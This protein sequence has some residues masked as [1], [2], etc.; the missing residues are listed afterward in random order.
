MKRLLST[1]TVLLLVAAAVAIGTWQQYRQFTVT[2]LEVAQPGVVLNVQPGDTLGAVV[3]RLGSQG[4]TE[5]GWRWRLLNRLR[6]VTIKTGE[7][8]LEP[9][10]TPPEM[11]DL[12]ASGKVVSYRF[13]IIEGWTVKQLLDALANEAVLQ[14]TLSDV[15]VLADIP[16]MPAGH[17]EGWF[18][19]ETYNFVRGDSDVEL[20]Q[21]AHDAMRQSLADTWSKRDIGLPYETPYE[22]LTM[23]SIIE[24]ETSLES[25]RH[26]IAGVFVRRLADNWRLEA[27]PTIIYGMGEDYQGDIR[28]RDIRQDTPYNT[29]TRRG[30]PPTPIALPGQA[31]LQAAAHPAPGETMFFVANGQ[32]G[33]TFSITLNEHNKAV[34]QLIAQGKKKASKGSGK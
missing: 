10:M 26:D 15:S 2:P 1:A 29:Y 34:R 8:R 30:L 3:A 22:L 11:L 32:G 21:R 5:W 16:G 4:V 27:D 7:Y 14:H 24:K 19:P 33:H 25:E 9:G 17:P 18:L 6:Q 12:L 13:T 23:A 20:L 28:R 31:S